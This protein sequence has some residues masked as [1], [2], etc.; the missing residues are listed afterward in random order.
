MRF[1]LSREDRELARAEREGRLPASTGRTLPELSEASAPL[2]RVRPAFDPLNCVP[3]VV[4]RDEWD[5]VFDRFQDDAPSKS[6]E[7]TLMRGALA[8][9]ADLADR[10]NRLRERAIEIQGE[11]RESNQANLAPVNEQ[12]GAAQLELSTLEGDLRTK[13]EDLRQMAREN[14][15]P[16]LRLLSELGVKAAIDTRWGY[17]PRAKSPMEKASEE[18]PKRDW[19]NVLSLI[20]GTVFGWGLLTL[21]GAMTVDDF[22]S[23]GLMMLIGALVGPAIFLFLLSPIINLAARHWE[24]YHNEE[25]ENR[26]KRKHRAFGFFGTMVFFGL[27]EVLIEKGGFQVAASDYIADIVDS[28]GTVPLFISHPVYSEITWTVVACFLGLLFFVLKFGHAT[29]LIEDRLKLAAHQKRFEANQ[30]RLRIQVQDRIDK[31]PALRAL[32]RE[33]GAYEQVEKRV[34]LKRQTVAELTARRNELQSKTP[35]SVA[36][37]GMETDLG[38]LRKRI[39]EGYVFIK[40][41]LHGTVPPLEVR[42]FGER[43]GQESRTFYTPREEER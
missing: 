20:C 23:P 43:L 24:E 27:V 2:V 26:G 40:G 17:D 11:L 30:E 41:H 32:L 37:N 14:G 35:T 1:N 22:R 29:E 34:E 42:P 5:A 4:N 36:L 13:A 25:S 12:L 28:G 18:P 15:L 7:L 8:E 21:M 19:T 33:G 9:M 31:T 39:D 38:D 3:L 6:Y 10:H 16:Q